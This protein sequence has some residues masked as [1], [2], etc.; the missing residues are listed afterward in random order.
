[1]LLYFLLGILT[2]TFSS[3]SFFKQKQDP[4]PAVQ[5][6]L[7]ELNLYKLENQKR[8][9]AGDLYEHSLWTHYAATALI[10]DQAPWVANFNFSK[11]DKELLSLA[12][13]LHDI[14]KAGRSELFDGTHPTLQYRLALDDRGKPVKIAYTSDHEEHVAVGFDY[15]TELWA[16]LEQG[17]QF[18]SSR[19]M[20]I[21]F[22]PLFT[23]LKVALE[24]QKVVAILVGMHYSFGRI[25]RGDL[26]F[27]DFLRELTQYAQFVHYD[28]VDERLLRLAVLVQV[29]DVTGMSYVKPRP[30]W[31]MPT[32]V[33]CSAVHRDVSSAY[34]RFGYNTTRPL[35]VFHELLAYFE[36]QKR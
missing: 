6:L 1:M 10:E 31:I 25:L 30:T 35:A 5:S 13:L 27:D 34:N 7:N 8:L 12:A 36:Q 22:Q 16:P 32:P 21:S 18:F 19:G 33:D 2:C 9:H 17:R 3:C 20:P 14:G 23:Q 24:E 4:V 26:S 11:R 28:S 15:L 29:A